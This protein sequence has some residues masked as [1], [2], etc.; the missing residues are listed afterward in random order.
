MKRIFQIGILL[1]VSVLTACMKD[2][3]TDCDVKLRFAYTYNMKNTN[4]FSEEVAQVRVWVFD[5]EQRLVDH[6]SE[7]RTSWDNEDFFSIP[8]LHK[9]D[10]TFVTMARSRDEIGDFSDYEIADL[11]LGEPIDSLWARLQRDER[12]NNNCRLNNFLLGAQQVSITGRAQHITLELMKYTNT[13][14]ILLMPANEEEMLEDE[15]LDIWI[16]GKNG[17]L[18]YDGKN[19]REDR[20]IYRPYYQTTLRE[21]DGKRGVVHQVTVAELSTSRFLYDQEPRLIVRHKVSGTEIIN[22]NLAWLLSLQAIGEHQEKWSN[23]EYLDRQDEYALTFFVSGQTW[24]QS[25][26]IVNG[27]VLSFSDIGL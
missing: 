8:H 2:D 5:E 6:Y 10:Y 25:Q 26:I 9:G 16:E 13:V 1:L 12:G 21:E 22:I 17:W 27:W 20:L 23:Q 4:A 18:T 24:L 15:Q 3:I 19:Y 11:S 14:R 7:Q